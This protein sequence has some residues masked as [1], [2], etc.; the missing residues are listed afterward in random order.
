MRPR[1][2]IPG[3]LAL[4]IFGIIMQN[5]L[6]AERAVTNT[7]TTTWSSNILTG[8]EIGFRSDGAVVWRWTA[9]LSPTNLTSPVTNIMGFTF[10]TIPV[11]TITNVCEIIGHEWEPGCGKMGCAVLH[12]DAPM[13]HCKHCGAM[14]TRELGPWK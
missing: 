1:Y 10:E 6:N 9:G 8:R 3:C 14:Q 5:R 12:G 11:V 7:M 4:I 2:F 13:R